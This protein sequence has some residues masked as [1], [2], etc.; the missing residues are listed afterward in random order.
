MPVLRRRIYTDDDQDSTDAIGSSSR[1]VDIYHL[2]LGRCSAIQPA[3][4]PGRISIIIRGPRG[5]R[6]DRGWGET[7]RFALAAVRL[8]VNFLSGQHGRAPPHRAVQRNG[9]LVLF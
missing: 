3:V 2:W 5:S 1:L 6:E 4:T 7:R 9:R 8:M